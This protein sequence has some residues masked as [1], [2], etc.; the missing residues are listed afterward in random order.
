MNELYFEKRQQSIY[1]KRVKILPDYHKINTVG[2]MKKADIIFRIVVVL[3]LGICTFMYFYS[4]F[5]FYVRDV[6]PL[7]IFDESGTIKPE[8]DNV[9]YREISDSEILYF[10][11]D[12]ISCGSANGKHPWYEPIT[13]AVDKDVRSFAYGGFTVSDILETIEIDSDVSDKKVLFVIAL[14]TN[15][16]LKNESTS[17]MYIRNMDILIE[18]ILVSVPNAEFVLIAPWR[19]YGE[20]PDVDF[21]YDEVLQEI[22]DYSEALK[23]YSEQNGY[24]YIDSYN[25]IEE[26]INSNFSYL[27]ILD[28]IHPNSRF[29]IRVYSEAVMQYK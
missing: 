23:N 26:H 10:V 13:A 4:G 22:S 5:A 12:S 24:T 21:S 27:Y 29:G 25:Y 11:G 18:T 19:I 8:Y 20:V 9:F 28:R 15:D 1:A 16:I 3:L 17:E 6:K 2:D 14:G 7:D